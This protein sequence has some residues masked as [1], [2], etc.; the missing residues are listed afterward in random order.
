M[1]PN[2][3]ALV[4][5]YFNKTYGQFDFRTHKGCGEFTE[6]CVNYLRQF[7][8]NVGHLRKYGSATQWNG[9]AIDAINYHDVTRDTYQSVDL[10]GNAETANAT[11]QW[12]IQEVY[13][14]ANEWYLIS[15]PI[16]EPE[17][18]HVCPPPFVMPGY[19]NLGGDAL[20]RELVGVPLAADYKAANQSMN[21]GSVVW[22]NRTVYDALA[23]IVNDKMEPRAAYIKSC[24]KRRPE[25]R[26]ALGL[27]N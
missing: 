25:W 12:V 2:H 5:Y 19:E 20:C 6:G 11:P 15:E 16:P 18:P 9:H 1:V 24:E 23:F 27:D 8:L 3:R 22:T 17:P 4:E 26:R 21:D 13:Y 10:L 14:T 7:D